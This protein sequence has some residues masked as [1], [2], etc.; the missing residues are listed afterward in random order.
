MPRR[1]QW[2]NRIDKEDVRVHVG[3]LRE[4][5]EWTV[6]EERTRLLIER[7]WPCRCSHGGIE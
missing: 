2:I 6:V 7:S 3:G 1:S 4:S 5:E